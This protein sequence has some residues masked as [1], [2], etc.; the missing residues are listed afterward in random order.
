MPAIQRLVGDFQI[1]YTLA[2]LFRIA[3]RKPP[4]HQ[5]EPSQQC[6]VRLP[7]RGLLRLRLVSYHLIQSLHHTIPS[8]TTLSFKHSLRFSSQPRPFPTLANRLITTRYNKRFRC[9][10]LLISVALVCRTIHTFIQWQSTDK[11]KPVR[12]LSASEPRA[13]TYHTSP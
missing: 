12:F 8:T 9:R 6:A 3:S 2:K 4:D 11:V 7:L 13:T 10:S 1:V 5:Q